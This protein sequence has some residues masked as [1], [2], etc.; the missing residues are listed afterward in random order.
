MYCCMGFMP[1][2]IIM[3]YTI[4]LSGVNGEG[5]YAKV[6]ADDFEAL[7]AFKWYVGTYNNKTNVYRC[8]NY[9]ILYMHDVVTK[10]KKRE[11]V[12]HTNDNYLDCRKRNLK[13]LSVHEVVL[14]ARENTKSF[15]GVDKV[16]RHYNAYIKDQEGNIVD[17][18]QF[19]YELEAAYTHDKAARKLYGKKAKV[20]FSKDVS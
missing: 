9:K 16:G 15:I 14:A 11:A 18:G 8:A 1:M 10:R 2:D 20:N 12:I 4:P 7:S 6:D 13:V 19:I 5:L 3:S 17:L